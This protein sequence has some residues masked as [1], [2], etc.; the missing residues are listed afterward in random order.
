[1]SD[2]LSARRKWL[3]SALL[4]AC[5]LVGLGAIE[6]AARALFPQMAGHVV[7]SSKT[8]NKN[9]HLQPFSGVKIRV[10]EPGYEF[11]AERAQ[12]VLLVMGDSISFG[13]GLA[14]HDIYWQRWQ[15]LF[16]LRSDEP[17]QVVSPAYMGNNF[18]NN[19]EAIRRFVALFSDREIVG[20]VYQFNFN[21]IL[22]LRAEAIRAEV[23][24]SPLQQALM[25]FRLK[26]LNLS[27]AQKVLAHYLNRVRHSLR[28]KDCAD[29]GVDALG[30]YTYA[31]GA[32]GFEEVSSELWRSFDE[33]LAEIRE[34]A[35]KAPFFI[36][37]SPLAPQI[38]PRYEANYATF[39][40]RFDCATIDPIDQL[41][42]I[43]KANDIE[44]IDPTGYM[45][46][47]FRGSVAEGNPAQMY[48]FND[49]N[50]FNEIGASYFAEYSIQAL[51]EGLASAH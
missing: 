50:H 15:R 26:Y 42:R 34:L 45:A 36:L 11:D 25:A 39:Q 24:L 28:S 40:P 21:D 27:V 4:L 18:A 47:I 14:F 29:L 41:T 2:P 20:I 3:L 5:V 51:R 19:T 10:P 38:D 9:F 12:R 46:Q 6:L 31:Y 33:K 49:L 35:P 23:E 16:D 43:A 13:F 8:R 37:V 22:P 1:M 32:K 44:L 7:S 30:E 48:F 17:I